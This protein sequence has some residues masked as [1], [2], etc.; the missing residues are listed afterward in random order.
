MT[1]KWSQDW[2]FSLFFFGQKARYPNTHKIET[3][4]QFLGSACLSELTKPF[5]VLLNMFILANRTIYRQY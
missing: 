2:I 5:R 1:V 3:T 4:H